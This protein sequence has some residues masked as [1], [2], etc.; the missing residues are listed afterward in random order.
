[1]ALSN[2]EGARDLFYFILLGMRIGRLN[3]LDLIDFS[4]EPDSRQ[5]SAL[6]PSDLQ[7][8]TAYAIATELDRRMEQIRSKIKSGQTN[9][10]EDG[11]ANAISSCSFH[12]YARVLESYVPAVLLAELEDEL[13]NP[14]GV[15]TIRR[16]PLKIEGML[17]SA[18]CGVMIEFGDALGLL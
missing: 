13:E 9:P 8:R 14:S 18:D 12:L 11:A 10:E 17:L 5:L 3:R 16:P 6:V 7:N 4:V 2:Q 1:M 15:S